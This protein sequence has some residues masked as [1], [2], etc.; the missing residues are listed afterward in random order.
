MDLKGQVID[1]RS[2]VQDTEAHSRQHSGAEAS[3]NE[4]AAPDSTFVDHLEQIAGL[5]AKVLQLEDARTHEREQRAVDRMTERDTIVK[6]EGQLKSLPSTM[7]DEQKSR[8]ADLEKEMNSRCESLE[9]RLADLAKDRDVLKTSFSKSQADKESALGLLNKQ[10]EA[11]GQTQKALDDLRWQYDELITGRDRLMEHAQDVHREKASADAEVAALKARLRRMNLR[12]LYNQ[13]TSTSTDRSGNGIIQ[14][15]ESQMQ[16]VPLVDAP[17]SGVVATDDDYDVIQDSELPS[18]PAEIG[19]DLRVRFAMLR[20]YAAEL[21]SRFMA[22]RSN[23]R[24][25]DQAHERNIVSAQASTSQRPGP[26]PLVSLD[27]A[28]ENEHLQAAADSASVVSTALQEQNGIPLRRV[29][30]FASRVGRF[31]LPLSQLTAGR[32]ASN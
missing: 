1:L 2:Q 7:L 20:H 31:A 21:P 5:E 14:N 8:F 27:P 28:D 16:N 4:E 25:H 24:S 22:S 11:A 15:A 10:K 19:E 23:E 12:L 26:S 29:D 9:K 6:L 32:R 17:E 13:I 3:S 18:W 30:N